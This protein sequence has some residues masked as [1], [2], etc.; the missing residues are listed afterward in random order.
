MDAPDFV[1]QCERVQRAGMPAGAAAYR[2]QPIH[3]RFQRLFRMTHLDHV[4]KHQTAILMNT[5]HDRGRRRQRRNDDRH[6]VREHHL[7][8]VLQ[9]LVR[10]VDDQV[11]RKRRHLFLRMR[12]G[13][14]REFGFDAR[15]PLV[16][17]L[18]RPRIQRGERSDDAG[19]ALLDHQF[20]ARHHKHR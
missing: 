20:R 14:R 17:F 10:L 12:F 1:D 16:E 19:L 11:H 18:L 9:A 7:G 15:Q 5:R 4:V 2:D 3:A 6:L 13:I 8:V